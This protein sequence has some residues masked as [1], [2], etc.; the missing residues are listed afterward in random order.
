MTTAQNRPLDKLLSKYNNRDVSYISVEELQ[1]K[2]LNDSVYILDAR[3]KKEYEVSHL[4]EAIFVGYSSFSKNKFSH[5]F[6]DK[7]VPIVV[8]CS[9]GI[10]SENI[11]YKLQKAGYTNVSN[12]YGGIFEWK[13]T[14]YKVY[15]EGEETNKVHTFSK[16]WAKYLEKGEKVY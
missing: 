1:M 2:R 7:S 4:P 11:A 3:E 13:N 10:R 9:I 15:T 16:N 14:G 5:K 6:K 12:L 8:Y